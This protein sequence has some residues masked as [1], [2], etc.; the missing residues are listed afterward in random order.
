MHF[1]PSTSTFT[2][3]MKRNAKN[4]MI[5]R[6]GLC[7]SIKHGK[8]KPTTNGK[9]SLMEYFGIIIIGVLLIP[10]IIEFSQFVCSLFGMFLTTMVGGKD[11]K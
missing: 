8:R 6:I 9:K 4:A 3:L 2:D 5:E 10:A 7:G 1:K 11:E